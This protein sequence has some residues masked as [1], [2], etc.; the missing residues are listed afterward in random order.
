MEAIQAESCKQTAAFQTEVAKLTES[1][2]VQM[3]HEN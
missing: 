2:N 1:L 3:S